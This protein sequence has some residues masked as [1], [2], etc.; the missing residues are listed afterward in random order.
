[1]DLV[2]IIGLNVLSGIAS[3]VL[4]SLGLAIIFGM[5]RIINLA[6]GEFLMLGAY[7]TVVSTN[8]GV[9]VWIA[10]L[11]V[12]PIFV[13]LVGL[14][15]ERTLIRFLYGRLVDT[16]LA[17]WGLSLFIVG[18]ITTIFG[19]T[20]KGVPTPLGGFQVGAYRSDLYTLVLAFVALAL[21]VAVVVVMRFTRFGLIARATMQN[22]NMASALGVNPTRI[23]MLT[24]GIGAAVTGLAGGL[25]APVSGVSPTMGSAFIAKA[26]ITVVGGGA[27]ILAGTASAAMLFGFINQLGSYFTTPVFGEVILLVA[28]TVLIRILPEGITGR[29]FKGSL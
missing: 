8:L 2:A 23:Y 21:L 29:F 11:V 13:G 4:I 22:P 20:I 16:M 18:L 9:N 24:F 12:S 15:I 25:L 5:M 3:L 26:F 7:A 19:N 27:S 14:L 10:M 28:A 17:T 6:H 1:M